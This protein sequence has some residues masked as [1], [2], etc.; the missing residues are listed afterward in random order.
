MASASSP[1]TYSTCA[2]PSVAAPYSA[3]ASCSGV[4]ALPALRLAPKAA[5][6]LLMDA[7][8]GPPSPSKVRTSERPEKSVATA[9]GVNTF[10]RT[11]KG[12]SSWLSDCENPTTANLDAAYSEYSGIA[13]SPVSEA[14]L[15]ITPLPRSRMPGSTARVTASTPPTLVANWRSTTSGVAVSK[16]PNNP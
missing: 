16:G 10:T 14:T 1:V 4:I 6:A 3:C 11:P 7:A 12:A 13:T 2:L 15:M 9:P 8:Y 5:S